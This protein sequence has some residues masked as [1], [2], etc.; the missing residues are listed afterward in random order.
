VVTKLGGDERS[1]PVRDSARYHEL[2]AFLARRGDAVLATA[3]L[4]AGSRAGGE[5]L[6][7][8]ALERLVR[9]Y[10][11]VTGDPE[12]YLRRVLYNLAVDQWRLRGRRREV[13]LEQE[14]PGVTD[15]TD[16]LALREA[17][18]QA[19]TGLPARQRAVLVLRYWEQLSEAE[20]AH[21]LGCSV[22]TVKSSA[23]RG[24]TRLRELTADWA[25][26]SAGT[27]AATAPTRSEGAR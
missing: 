26:H 20:T 17:L 6:L 14:P 3:V 13:P 19:L 4:L 24:L 18:V 2:E 15:G 9:N 1:R 23:S 25:E 11:R 10:R 7:Q 5:D 12:G 8:T 27:A 16:G 22:G 21:A